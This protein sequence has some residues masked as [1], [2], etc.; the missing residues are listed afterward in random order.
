MTC[1]SFHNLLENDLREFD[2]RPLV[3][4]EER[5]AGPSVVEHAVDDAQAS[6]VAAGGEEQVR[7]PSG[8]LGQGRRGVEQILGHRRAGDERLINGERGFG[9]HLKQ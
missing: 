2:A 5:V 4:G 1:A 6:D 8:R 7:C 3:R 9:E